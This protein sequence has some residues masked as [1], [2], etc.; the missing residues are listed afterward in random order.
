MP[1]S[2]LVW[3]E[4]VSSQYPPPAEKHPVGP[5][6]RDSVF[7]QWHSQHLGAP[8]DPTWKWSG[9]SQKKMEA[10]AK[11]IKLTQLWGTQAVEIMSGRVRKVCERAT[12]PAKWLQHLGDFGH[13][14]NCRVPA[15]AMCLTRVF[16]RMGDKYYTIKSF[17][18]SKEHPHCDEYAS[19]L[20][21]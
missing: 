2:S 7:Q 20:A 6:P 9:G 18:F 12:D 1:W 8:K 17:F 13:V 19:P 21:P 3:T 4:P 15:L 16:V 11:T 5:M 10:E 14:K